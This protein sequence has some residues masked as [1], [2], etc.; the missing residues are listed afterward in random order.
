MKKKIEDTLKSLQKNAPSSEEFIAKCKE[1]VK[2]GYENPRDVGLAL[3][4]LF[5][6]SAACDLDDIA[7]STELSAIIDFHEFMGS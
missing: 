1:T 4:L 7:D 6:G 2:Y 3:G 5:I